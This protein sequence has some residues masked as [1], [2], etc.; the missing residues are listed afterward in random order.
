MNLWD[1]KAKSYARYNPKLNSI[2]KQSFEEFKKLNID[3]KD[4]VILDIACG[5]GVWSLHLAQRAKELIA[6]DSSKSMLDILHQ[7]AKEFKIDNIKTYHL[8]F[9]DFV[10]NHPRF[11]CDI[12]FLS[13]APVLNSKEACQNFIRLA[14]LRIYVTWHHYRQSD[15]LEPIFRHFNVKAKGFD[16]ENLEDFLTQNHYAFS[17]FIFDETRKVKRTQEEALENALWHLQ[18]SGAKVSK[19]EL[20]PLIKSDIDE[21]ITSKIKVLIF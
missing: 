21:T 9:E 20:R 11:H 8:S 19:D 14:A 16:K 18:M 13:M 12:A 4:K 7:D 15:F 17:R 2:Q 6:L 3:F 10:S 5:T 1:K